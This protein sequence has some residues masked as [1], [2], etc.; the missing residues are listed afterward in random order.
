MVR[1]RHHWAMLHSLLSLIKIS[2]LVL[3][4]LLAFP[5]APFSINFPIL[6]H[7]QKRTICMTLLYGISTSLWATTVFLPSQSLWIPAEWEKCTVI[8]IHKAVSVQAI[9][10]W[11]QSWLGQVSV[12]LQNA[13]SFAGTLHTGRTGGHYE[14]LCPTPAQ[15]SPV[16]L[17]PVLCLVTA[18]PCSHWIHHTPEEVG[19]LGTPSLH[20]LCLWKAKLTLWCLK[21]TTQVSSLSS[22][23]MTHSGGCPYNLYVVSQCYRHLDKILCTSERQGDVWAKRKNSA[24]QVSET[25]KNTVVPF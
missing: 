5:H 12:S 4:N 11:E 6:R 23:G 21:A 1:L 14:C 3:Q 22:E 18:W 8:C 2:A 16:F 20:K 25:G 17:G 10:D 24:A 9:D 13:W 15:P 7:V 19:C